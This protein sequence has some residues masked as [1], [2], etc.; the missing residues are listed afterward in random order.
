M[1]EHDEPSP[2]GTQE[3][4]G[5]ASAP[6]LVTNAE[7]KAKALAAANAKILW[8]KDKSP[9]D[10]RAAADALAAAQRMPD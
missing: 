7:K 10:Q 5:P 6:E 1:S 3:K 8:A 9:E 4:P 2:R